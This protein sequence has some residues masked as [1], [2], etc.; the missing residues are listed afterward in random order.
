M[1]RELVPWAT[2]YTSTHIHI[3]QHNTVAVSY[4][5][6]L[7]VMCR[8]LVP[9]A[10]WYTSTHIHIHKQTHV[11][12]QCLTAIPIIIEGRFQVFQWFSSSKLV[13]K[14]VESCF[15]AFNYYGNGSTH[16]HLQWCAPSWYPEQY[17]TQAYIYIYTRTHAHTYTQIRTFAAVTYSNVQRVG[18]LSSIIHRRRPNSSAWTKQGITY[19][20]R[21]LTLI[22]YL[23][24]VSSGNIYIY[25]YIYTHTHTYSWMSSVLA[26]HKRARTHTQIHIKHM[27]LYA[28]RWAS[29]SLHH[30]SMRTRTHT[31]KYT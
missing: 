14:T 31:H 11:Q 16:S 26:S 23:F 12:L 18:A 30:T 3:Y 27:D 25:I 6:P 29:T 10:A 20:S 28:C 24:C 21:D 13:L 2:L 4:T 5:P 15:M 9:W 19:L 17:D 7:T 1:C 22:V 8:E